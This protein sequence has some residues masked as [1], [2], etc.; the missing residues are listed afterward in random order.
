MI[1]PVYKKMFKNLVNA[2]E[3]SPQ[4]GIKTE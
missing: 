4:I 1:D 2:R 3:R